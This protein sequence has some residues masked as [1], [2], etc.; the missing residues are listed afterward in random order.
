MHGSTVQDACYASISWFA[1]T[2]DLVTRTVRH[3]FRGGHRGSL[4]LVPLCRIPALG[5]ATRLLDGAR[6]NRKRS[7]KMQCGSKETCSTNVHA[8]YDSIYSIYPPTFGIICRLIWAFVL[9]ET[10]GPTPP[11]IE[12]TG[13]RPCCSKTAHDP[14][15]TSSSNSS[16]VPRAWATAPWTAGAR[17]PWWTSRVALDGSRCWRGG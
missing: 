14:R 9:R 16:E 3:M 4:R 6:Q 8:Q 11:S 13:H 5:K 2:N 17:P 10:Q 7:Y 1:W 15:G 12:A